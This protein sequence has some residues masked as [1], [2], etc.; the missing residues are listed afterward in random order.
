M[1]FFLRR[2]NFFFNLKDAVNWFLVTFNFIF[3]MVYVEC[4]SYYSFCLVSCVQPPMGWSIPPFMVEC[5]HGFN[6]L[7]APFLMNWTDPFLMNDDRNWSLCLK[8]DHTNFISYNLVW[9]IFI[10]QLVPKFLS[11]IFLTTLI[12]LTY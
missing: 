8:I 3:L 9:S 11:R 1:C 10:S 7:S 6:P 12:I 4:F 2:V 5:G